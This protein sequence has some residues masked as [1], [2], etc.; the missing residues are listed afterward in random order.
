[1]Y[2]QAAAL[3][4]RN[5]AKEPLAAT[6]FSDFAKLNV[7]EGHYASAEPLDK[8]ALGILE[9]D[10]GSS[11]SRLSPILG[12]LSEIFFLQG[13]YTEATTQLQRQLEIQEKVLGPDN[14]EIAS[15]L[16]NY[17]AV[18]LKTDHPAEAAQAAARAKAIRAKATAASSDPEN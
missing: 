11:S 16:D 2:K 13:R 7:A 5:F 15:I 9:E 10:F 18:L 17:S 3:A 1:M 12:G 6:I 8:R 14:P 4:D